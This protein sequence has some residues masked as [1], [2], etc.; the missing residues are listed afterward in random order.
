MNWDDPTERLALIERVGVSEYN[1]LL[2]E[3]IAASTCCTVNGH[4]IRPVF[5]RFG[6]L[7][8]VG[9]TGKAFATLDEARKF[10]NDT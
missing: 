7:F 10:A 2:R 8:L 4:D 1:R 6:R 5:C 9:D 3:Y